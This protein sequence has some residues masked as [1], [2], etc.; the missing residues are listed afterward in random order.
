MSI[1][2]LVRNASQLGFLLFESSS[3]FKI[4]P[5]KL[6]PVCCFNISLDTNATEHI[7][8]GELLQNRLRIAQLVVLWGPCV[9][10]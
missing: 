8:E 7:H 10:P 4:F 1:P 6:S 9:Y 3:S 2:L 5:K